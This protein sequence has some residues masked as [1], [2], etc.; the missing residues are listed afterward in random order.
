MQE[1]LLLPDVEDEDGAPFWSAAARGEFRVQACGD[2]GRLRFPPRPMCPHCRSTASE[3]RELSG[4][5]TIWSFAIVHPPLLPAYAELAPYPVV[6]VALAEDASIRMVG[7]LVAGAEAAVNSVDPQAIRIGEE[8]RVA[9]AE[10]DGVH[11][12]RW[13][14]AF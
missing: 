8:V 10:V 11:L 3:W 6:V 1:T 13:V 12:P 7:N 14:K 4:R 9:F 5:G 2:C